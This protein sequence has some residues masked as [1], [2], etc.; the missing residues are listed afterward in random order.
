MSGKSYKV[1]FQ[2]FNS[3]LPK[4]SAGEMKCF[5]LL[6]K[7]VRQK[8]GKWV[9]GEGDEVWS[10]IEGMN[11]SEGHCS[12]ASCPPHLGLPVLH[13]RT[14]SSSEFWCSPCTMTS[15]V[16][17]CSPFPPQQGGS[18]KRCLLCGSA[19]LWKLP[20]DVRLSSIPLPVWICKWQWEVT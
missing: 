16:P 12:F 3:L 17:P 6:L 1:I 13:M 4:V 18:S 10:Q 11:P 20:T 2:H 7:L 15:L 8:K 9:G 5:V 14:A 19:S